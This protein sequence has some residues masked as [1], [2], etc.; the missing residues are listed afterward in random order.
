[1]SRSKMITVVT[2]LAILTSPA[3]SFAQSGGAGGGGSAGGTSA[4]GAASDPSG[5]G[6]ASRIAP[7]PSPGTNSAGTAQSSGAGVNTGAGVT[8]GAAGTGTMARP[9]GDVD[10]A[11]ND[12]NKTIDRKL[13]GICR[14]C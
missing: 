4:G 5:A 1:M 9:Q 14:G 8:T 2:A 3:I 13:K 11:I 10:A 7:P 12:E 6:N